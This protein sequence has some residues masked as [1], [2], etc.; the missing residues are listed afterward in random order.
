MTMTDNSNWN[1]QTVKGDPLFIITAGQ[2]A[3]TRPAQ[4]KQDV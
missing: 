4:A 2:Q 3:Q 1:L